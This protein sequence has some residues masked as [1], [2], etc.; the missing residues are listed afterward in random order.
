M[1][2]VSVNDILALRDRFLIAL[3]KIQDQRNSNK[4]W[5]T[6]ERV[7]MSTL[8]QEERSKRGLP[9]L[10][11]KD[12]EQAENLALGHTDYSRKFC[13]YCAELVFFGKVGC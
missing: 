3:G 12:I 10:G 8:V 5:I 11:L 4:D 1:Q 2:S 6:H 13:L 7:V 9:R